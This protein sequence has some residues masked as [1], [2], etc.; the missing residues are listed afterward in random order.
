MLRMLMPR[1]TDFAERYGKAPVAIVADGAIAMG[2]IGDGRLI[3]VL[4]IE[5]S[6]RP[7]IVHL[8]EAQQ[9]ND[10]GDVKLQWTRIKGRP[11]SIGI[12]LDFERPAE[13]SFCI[14]FDIEDQGILVEQILTANAAYIQAG[15]KGDRLSDNFNAPKL[16]FEVPD[17]GLRTHWDKIYKKYLIKKARREGLSHRE[18]KKVAD[19]FVVEWQK[20]GRSRMRKL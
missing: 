18:A 10:P 6:Q 19:Q 1:W 13:C 20:F 5:C 7:D 2:R 9:H 8:I 16:L 4:I 3:P 15:R 17:T 12:L 11:H 14:S